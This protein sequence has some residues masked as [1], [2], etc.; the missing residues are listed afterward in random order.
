MIKRKDK[1]LNDTAPQPWDRKNKFFSIA[2]AWN[3]DNIITG[4][5][6]VLATLIHTAA[7][8]RQ[9]E[10]YETVQK[11][12]GDINYDPQPSKKRE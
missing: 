3:G 5:Q 9:G 1:V 7:Q 2:W 6:M 11:I 12:M 4:E 8:G 10:Q